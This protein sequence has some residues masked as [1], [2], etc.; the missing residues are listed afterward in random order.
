MD[1]LGDTIIKQEPATTR[2]LERVDRLFVE[3]DDS[4][5]PHQDFG[6]STDIVTNEDLDTVENSDTDQDSETDDDTVIT[7]TRPVT[8]PIQRNRHPAVLDKINPGDRRKHNIR[9]RDILASGLGKEPLAE[10]DR[11]MDAHEAYV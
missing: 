2:E 9:A 7:V 8:R 3:Q 4:S 6:T 5:N 1:R 10:I 11:V